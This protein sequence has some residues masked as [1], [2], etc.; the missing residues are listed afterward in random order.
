MEPIPEDTA[1]TNA[2]ATAQNSQT[3]SQYIDEQLALEADAKEI[4]PYKFDK[5]TYIQGPLRQSVFACLTCSPPPASAAQVYTP[6]GICYSCSISCH[7]DHN[8]VELFKRRHFVCDC[9]TTRMPSTQPCMLRSD[10][11]TAR[12]GVASQE[13]GKDNTYNHNYQNKFCG[14]GEEYNPHEEKGTMYQCLGLGSVE[15]GGCAEDW[16]HPECLMGLPRD[17]SAKGLAKPRPEKKI[18]GQELAESEHPVPEGFPEDDDFTTLI[19]Y[20]CVESNPWIKQYA[21]TNGFLPPIHKIT[22]QSDGVARE[23]S[24]KRKASGEEL[25]RPSSPSKRLKEEKP[26]ALLGE[27]NTATLLAE[28]TTTEDNHENLAAAATGLPSNIVQAKHKH[29]DLPPAPTALLSILAKEDFRDKLCHCPQCFPNLVPHPQLQE[30]EDEY[31][32]SI[33]ASEQSL[34]GGASGTRSVGTGSILERGEAALST[35]DRVKAIEGVMVYNHLKDKVKEFLK[36]YAESGEAVSAD[37]I[38]G[39]F[40][41]LRGDQEAMKE[42]REKPIPGEGEDGDNRR[43]QSGY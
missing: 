26:E 30:E 41:K 19:C 38:K 22:P 10:P 9:G 28:D 18:E 1:A 29:E 2:D 21:G 39:Y 6:A 32:P 13:P 37:D 40:E 23:G 11:A 17:W 16:W 14:C 34:A 5:C 4:L 43:E 20:K 31:E 12:K 3:A 35:M 8:L 15:A 24:L 7:G 33:S 42:A 25:A 27:S 36:P